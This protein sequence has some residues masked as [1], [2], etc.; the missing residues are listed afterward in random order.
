MNANE[1]K[2]GMAL[3]VVLCLTVLA[4]AALLNLLLARSREQLVDWL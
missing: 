2:R 1:S 3:V 4:T